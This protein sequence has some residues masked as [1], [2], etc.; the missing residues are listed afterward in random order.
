[1][2]HGMFGGMAAMMAA[3]G[4]FYLAVVVLAALGVGW[5]VR[6][7][8]QR[9]VEAHPGAEELLRRRYAAGEIG[10][11]EFHERSAGLHA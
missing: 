7:R 4:V 2:M 10:D 3:S 11:D 6:T 8:R 5:L 9:V 1:M